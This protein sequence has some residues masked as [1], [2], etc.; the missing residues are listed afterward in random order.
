MIE[1]E[2]IANTELPTLRKLF[3]SISQQAVEFLYTDTV[4][5][6]VPVG[7]FII[8]D[9]GAGTKRLYV[10]TGKGNIGFVNLT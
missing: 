1:L 3:E 8:Y 4:P 6:T 7:K 9:D 10:K 2:K 5:T